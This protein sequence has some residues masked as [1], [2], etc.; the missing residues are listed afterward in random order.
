MSERLE[1]IIESSSSK[2]NSRVHSI[3]NWLNCIKAES[4]EKILWELAK[5][6]KRD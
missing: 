6:K 2:I 3:N 5:E 1:K 4:A